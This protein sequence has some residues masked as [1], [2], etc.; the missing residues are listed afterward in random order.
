[1]LN[2]VINE[3]KRMNRGQDTANGESSATTASS[4]TSGRK[5]GFSRKISINQ[6]MGESSLLK[7]FF[8]KPNGKTT[9]FR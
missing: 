3:M 9:S 1:M 4:E 8:K 2:E 5:V 7:D 6:Y